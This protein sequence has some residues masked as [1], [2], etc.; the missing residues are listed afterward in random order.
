MSIDDL[1]MAAM[2]IMQ[3]IA[4][5]RTH[6]ELMRIELRLRDQFG[7][8]EFYVLMNE[9]IARGATVAGDRHVGRATVA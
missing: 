7:G 4:P 6:P 9:T 1:V 3:E 5:N 8:R 2:R